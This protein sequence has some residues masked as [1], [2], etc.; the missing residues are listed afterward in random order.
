MRATPGVFRLDG[1]TCVRML[2]QFMLA[3]GIGVWG[4]MVLAP[5]PRPSGPLLDTAPPSA[6]DTTPLARWFGGAAL[7][8]RITP[9][10]VIASSEGDGAALLSVDGGPARAYRVGTQLAPG[11]VLHA[12]SASS[13][14]IDQDGVIESVGLPAAAGVVHGF[15]PVDAR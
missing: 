14:S 9:V 5:A 11:V 1:P 6:L 4:A 13:I 12:V 8:V 7:R 2:G 15:L 10:G 3:A